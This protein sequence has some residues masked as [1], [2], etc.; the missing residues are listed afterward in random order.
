[1]KHHERERH[2]RAIARNLVNALSDLQNG[3][4]AAALVQ[5]AIAVVRLAHLAPEADTA[6][7]VA[8][9]TGRKRKA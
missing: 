4:H 5:A 6:A 8:R 3:S 1:M 9:V 7:I 2:E